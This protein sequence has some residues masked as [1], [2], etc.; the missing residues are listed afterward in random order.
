MTTI[1]TAN[2]NFTANFRVSTPLTTASNEILDNEIGGGGDETDF[3][4]WMLESLMNG[5]YYKSDTSVSL[6]VMNNTVYKLD[7]VK[8]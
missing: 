4:N 8:S 3:N 5:E 6:K 1:T 7:L 2:T